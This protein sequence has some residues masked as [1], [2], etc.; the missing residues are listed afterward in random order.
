MATDVIC[1]QCVQPVKRVDA[2]R[3]EISGYAH[4]ICAGCL[5]FM[6]KVVASK[7][8]DAFAKAVRK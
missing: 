2:F 5:D 1:L 6:K 3:V 7:Q 8:M 4:Y